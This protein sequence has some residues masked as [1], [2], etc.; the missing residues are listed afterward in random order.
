MGR[1][2]DPPWAILARKIPMAEPRPNCQNNAD[3]PPPIGWQ[4]MQ[5]M[6]TATWAMES[7]HGLRKNKQ[8]KPHDAA[9]RFPRRHGKTQNPQL[10]ENTAS[11]GNTDPQRLLR[12]NDNTHPAR[13]QTKTKP[14]NR[15]TEPTERMTE[16]TKRMTLPDHLSTPPPPAPRHEDNNKDPG[17]VDR[18]RH[19][20]ALP[21]PPPQDHSRPNHTTTTTTPATK[22]EFETMPTSDTTKSSCPGPK[23]SKRTQ[24]ANALQR[25]ILQLKM[26]PPPPNNQTNGMPSSQKQ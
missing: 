20:Q 23:V 16:P 17:H 14:N 7:L 6:A 4:H 12:S 21:R 8:N 24:I 1:D 3:P 22:S 10:A 9:T 19:Q 26:T 11:N 2:A 18:A 15:M 13:P 25:V 5:R